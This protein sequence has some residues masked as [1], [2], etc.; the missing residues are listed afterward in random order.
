MSTLFRIT[1]DTADLPKMKADFMASLTLLARQL[2]L[3]NGS[4]PFLYPMRL[5]SKWVFILVN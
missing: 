3:L 2:I 5:G 4:H 1:P